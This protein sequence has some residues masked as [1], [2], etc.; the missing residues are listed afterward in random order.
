MKKPLARFF[1]AAAIACS[2]FAVLGD[3]R[4]TNGAGTGFNGRIINSSGS[5]GSTSSGEDIDLGAY[6]EKMRG[7]AFALLMVLLVGAGLLAAAGKTQLA[8]QTAIGTILMFGA[9]WLIIEIARA[10]QVTST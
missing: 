4:A 10:L 1:L 2:L 9:S 3:A 8:W 6:Y 5:S 7:V